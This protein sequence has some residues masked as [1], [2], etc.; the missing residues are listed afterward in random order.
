MYSLVEASTPHHFLLN[1]FMATIEK[2]GAVI[3]PVLQMGTQ[4]L[5]TCPKSQ[6]EPEAKVNFEAV[7]IF[8]VLLQKLCCKAHVPALASNI[9]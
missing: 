5:L 9:S 4:N 7:C 6:R 2:Q 3:L 8:R 1:Y